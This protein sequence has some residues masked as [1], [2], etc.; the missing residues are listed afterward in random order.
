[1]SELT[2]EQLEQLLEE[3]EIDA[4][5]FAFPILNHDT[6][7]RQ[8]AEAAERENRLH[9]MNTSQLV[10]YILEHETGIYDDPETI[11]QEAESYGVEKLL[12]WRGR[13]A[14]LETRVRELEFDIATSG[15]SSQAG[16]SDITPRT[17][18]PDTPTVPGWYWWRGI[19]HDEDSPQILE[20]AHLEAMPDKALCVCFN[21]SYYTRLDTVPG[22]WS[23]PI[24]M[25][26][27]A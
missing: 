12:V 18:T 1:M 10:S 15:I 19:F 8:R 27:E 6:A 21:D 11:Q 3:A 22:K 16:R 25:P 14:E 24:P 13:I 2:R 20:V 26:K 23:G 17:W 9:L 7:L 4:K 5:R